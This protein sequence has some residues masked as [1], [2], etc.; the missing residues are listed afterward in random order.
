MTGVQTCALPIWTNF[1]WSLW[2][3]GNKL[4]IAI[5]QGGKLVSA[6]ATLPAGSSQELK[7]SILND[8]L[9]LASGEKELTSVPCSP[10]ISDHPV[11]GL[12][13]GRDDGGLVGDYGARN[14][15]TGEVTTLKIVLR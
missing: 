14:E 10:I 7:A 2:V 4:T 9:V 8:R 5:R 6:N 12:E 3:D 11:D 15:F 1:G 13:V